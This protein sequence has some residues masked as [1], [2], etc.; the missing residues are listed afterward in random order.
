MFGF[1]LFGWAQFGCAKTFALLALAVAAKVNPEGGARP[2][3]RSKQES[4]TAKAEITRSTA[5]SGALNDRSR[6][7][8]FAYLGVLCAFA[9][10]L[11]MVRP[12]RRPRTLSEQ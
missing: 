10:S 6:L 2:L 11:C 5:K 1:G 7:G 12:G 3:N 4:E 8:L 9:V